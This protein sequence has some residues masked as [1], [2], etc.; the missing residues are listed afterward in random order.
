TDK[1]S[2]ANIDINFD[3]F[4]NDKINLK[5][6]ESYKITENFDYTTIFNQF[7]EDFYQSA[8][9]KLEKE[10]EKN[11]KNKIFILDAPTG[12]GKT[13][14]MFGLA[15]LLKNRLRKKEIYPQIIYSLPFIS[16]IDQNYKVLHKILEVSLER[17]ITTD[18]I[19]PFHHL[20]DKFFESPSEE[21]ISFNEGSFLIENWHSKIIVTSFFQIFKSIFTNQNH[22]L[23][24]FNKLTNSIIIIDEIQAIPSYLHNIISKTL[25]I[26]SD[27]FGCLIIIGTATFPKILNFDEEI[28]LI[29]LYDKEYLGNKY[30]LFER[31][32]LFHRY[33]VNL[34][35][36]TNKKINMSQLVDFIYKDI[37]SNNSM[38]KNF[39]VIL[40]TVE[41]SKKIYN[42]LKEKFKN[43]CP[44]Y[45]STN[46]PPVE[47]LKRINQIKNFSSETRFF[48]VS[49]QVIE[50]GVD[51]SLEKI[52]RDMAPLDSI[53]QTCGRVNRNANQ[54]K[55]IVYLFEL[56]DEE[57]NSESFSCYIYDKL[58]LSET[59]YLLNGI[60]SQSIPEYILSDL[61]E[62]YFERLDN[63]SQK[64]YVKDKSDNTIHLPTLIEKNKH[65][66]V[67][68]YFKLIEEY[69]E[70]I[71]IFVI[72]EREFNK[73]K[74]FPNNPK[75][76]WEKYKEIYTNKKKG[77]DRYLYQKREFEKIKRP[78]YEQCVNLRLSNKQKNEI[79]KKL[80]DKKFKNIYFLESTS[81]FYDKD[82]GINLK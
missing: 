67:E 60:D 24:R 33:E 31:D 20:S 77:L 69:D 78:F 54:M 71:T 19:L 56:I 6:I 52:Y 72:D 47:R 55:G 46:I 30:N 4:Q 21:E 82:T 1:K 65:A 10:L 57:N 23:Q 73:K 35:L 34:S 12:S 39:G 15:L 61:C 48:V 38:Q 28:E 44:I 66:D 14:T 41:S 5:S 49:T 9:K 80:V 36:A 32:G 68:R 43:H 40:N 16:I 7:R 25:E 76:L 53:V 37:V 79:L 74:D 81:E 70:E 45:L 42:I 59:K 63:I 64:D 11:E 26:L 51:I 2:A 58:L 17:K 27:K 18:L 75:E 3:K 50:A 29:E 62:K 13:L 22:L 8:I